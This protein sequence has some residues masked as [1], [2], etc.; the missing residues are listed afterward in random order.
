M[1]EFTT[2]DF[3]IDAWTPETLP[4]GRLAEYAAC[5]AKLMGSEAHVHLL[6]IRKGSAV[7]EIAVALTAEPKVRQRLSLVNASDAPDDIKS[8]WRKV[9]ALLRD[10]NATAVLRV[11]RGATV[12]EFPGRKTPLS[13][14]VVV[15]QQAELDGVVIRVGGKDESVPVWLQGESGEKLECNAT[16]EIAKQLAQYLF[17]A[18]V[19]VAG[20]AKWRRTKERVWELA[21]FDIK[22]FE[23]LDQTPLNEL[24]TKLRAIDTDWAMI[25]DPQAELRKLRGA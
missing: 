10:D 1:G 12:L 7:P 16:R 23:L 11:K 17:E 2:F 25:D 14:E 20:N 4:M 18:P 21:A 19:R 9:N 24:V 13:E 5:L 22:S 6:K 8:N 15:H 3:R